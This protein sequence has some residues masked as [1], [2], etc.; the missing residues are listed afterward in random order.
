MRI[1]AAPLWGRIIDRLGAQPVLLACSL[2]IGVIPSIW[3]FPT[4]TFLWPL[5]LDVVLAGVLWGG[6]GLA[7][8]ALPLSVAPRQGRPFYL[9]AFSTAGGLAYAA[10]SALGGGLASLLPNEFT[11]GGHL[12]VNLHVLFALSAVTRVAAAFLAMRIVEPGARP[13]CS[14]GALSSLVGDQLRARS[15]PVPVP[16]P[17]LAEA[18]SANAE[19]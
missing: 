7:S 2:G 17:V 4:A 1:L 3:L 10:A 12:W 11:L 5:L 6:H 13:V 8:F 16:A 9:A 15:M 18:Q 14:L 19:S